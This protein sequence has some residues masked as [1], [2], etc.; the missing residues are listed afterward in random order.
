MRQQE[1]RDE[2]GVW[3]IADFSLICMTNDGIVQV[4]D[5]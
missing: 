2:M 3:T 4:L 1:A 5:S